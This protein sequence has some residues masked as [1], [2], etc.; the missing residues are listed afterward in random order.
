D[1]LAITG[2]TLNWN[3]GNWNGLINVQSGGTLNLTGAGDKTLIG[4]TIF[5]NAGTTNWLLGNFALNDAS[6]FDNQ[7]G[8]TFNAQCDQNLIGQGTPNTGTFKNAGTFTKSVTTGTTTVSRSFTNTGLVDVQS[9]SLSFNSG[10]ISS[11]ASGNTFNAA[12]GT[13]IVF[14]AGT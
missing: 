10:Q 11:S 9:G 2:G 1:S 12:S 6:L 3:G 13:H 5:H 7:D 14:N 4:S 8:G